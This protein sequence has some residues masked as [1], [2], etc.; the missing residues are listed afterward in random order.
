MLAA[1]E[2]SGRVR[3]AFHARGW[4]AWS[5]DLLP[6][7]IPSD[8]HIQGDVRDILN[9]HWDLLVAH[10]SCQYLCNSGVRWLYEKPGR[11]DDMEKAAAFYNLF[12]DADHIPFRVI[13]NPVMH[14]YA[15]Q[16]LTHYDHVCT[17]QPWEHGHREMKCTCLQLVNLPPLQPSDIVGPPPDS[18]RERAAWAVVHR[19]SPGPERWKERSRTYWG[20]AVALADQYTTFILEQRTT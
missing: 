2:F 5:C 3:E 4:D 8:H 16:L 9:D 17:F 13:E 20:V 7:E 11:W 19:A 18:L 14:L 6:T 15:K 12:L 1:C 10:P